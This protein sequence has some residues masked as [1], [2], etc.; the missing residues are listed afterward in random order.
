MGQSCLGMIPVS[1]ACTWF[2]VL[3]Y[4]TPVIIDILT[5]AFNWISLLQPFIP[6]FNYP[7]PKNCSGGNTGVFINGRELHQKDLDLLVGR[8]LPDSPGRSYRVE[9]S[10]KVSDEVSGE[11]LCLGKLAPT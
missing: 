11:E 9:M 2:R 1:K 5:E 10:G 3:L 4:C 8:G 7:M 6:E